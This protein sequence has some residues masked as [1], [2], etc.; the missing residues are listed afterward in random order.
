MDCVHTVGMRTAG[1]P[2]DPRGRHDFTVWK[3]VRS[4]EA[5]S[6]GARTGPSSLRVT[7]GKMLF[8]HLNHLMIALLSFSNLEIQ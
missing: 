1:S 8:F 5:W 2:S 6:G 7:Q 3:V 4:P